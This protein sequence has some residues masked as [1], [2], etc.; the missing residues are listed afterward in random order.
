MPV[1]APPL[2]A[3]APYGWTGFYAGANLGYSVGREEASD[4]NLLTG[5]AG[6]FSRSE[7][8]TVGPTGAIGG[9]QFGYNWQVAPNWVIGLEADIQ[10]TAQRESL[11]VLACTFKVEQNLPWLATVRGRAGYTQNGWLWYVTAGGAFGRVDT[12]LALGDGLTASSGSFSDTRAGFAAG[13]GVE[14]ALGGRWTTKLEYLYVD[15]GTTTNTVS[16]TFPGNPIISTDSMT[17][18]T[19]IV[20]HIFRVGFNYRL[21][22]D[23]SDGAYA[24][25]GFLKAPPAYAARW[26]GFYAGVNAGYSV[27]KGRFTDQGGFN[28]VDQFTVSPAGAL[29]GGQV[30]YNWMPDR[31]VVLGIEADGDW[32]DEKHS[33]CTGLCT[34]VANRVLPA[35]ALNLSQKID[36]LSTVR[37]RAGYAH[38]G[39][40]YY[41]TLGVAFARVEETMSFLV[42]TATTTASF[43]HSRVGLAAGVGVETQFG[44]NWSA[45]LEYLYV[46][47]GSWTNV[48]PPIDFGP[49]QGVAGPEVT[50]EKL[51]DHIIRVGLNYHLWP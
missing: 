3:P 4:F 21:T 6:T 29:A 2:A 37:G 23:T 20:D 13:V 36:W 31:R 11:C 35:E 27:G 25:A 17:L 14:T 1:K 50:Q 15:L 51:T 22:G 18:R 16:L 46:D 47:L 5:G 24:S 39:W 19:P 44:G 38:G 45:K 49:P 34:A 41:A 32:T 10:A 12:N 48:T 40:L 33:S 26:D 30:G 9:G 28:P 8:F 7:T 43:S 42:N